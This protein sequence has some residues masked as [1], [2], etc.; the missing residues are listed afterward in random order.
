VSPQ[1]LE[2]E[3]RGKPE[4]KGSW[5]VSQQ[6]H[7]YADNPRLRGWADRVASEVA[8]ELNGTGL[9]LGSVAIIAEFRF[10]RPPSHLTKGGEVRKGK[11][12]APGRPDLDKLLR[13]LLDAL[14]GVVFKDDAQVTDLDACKVWAEVPGVM[15]R[16][17]DLTESEV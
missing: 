11:P 17:I 13:G 3:V 14:T 4:A 7:L 8:A 5:R 15:L 6:G 1:L 2:L 10:A 12:A 9:L 16:V